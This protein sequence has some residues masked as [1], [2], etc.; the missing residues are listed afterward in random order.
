MYNEIIVIGVVISLIYFELTGWSPGG[1]IVPGYFVLNLR[2]PLRVISTIAVVLVTWLIVSLLSRYVILYGQRKFAFCILLAFAL[3]QAVI[4][5]MPVN[6]GI[7][8]YLVPGILANQIDNQGFS[9]TLV[10]LVIVTAVLALI[11]FAAGIPV[12]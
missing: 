6:P 2:V 8:G 1:I 12:F 10:S 9:V 7:I 4:W 11:L 3:H 5:I